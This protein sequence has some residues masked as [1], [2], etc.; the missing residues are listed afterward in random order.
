MA[1]LDRVPEFRKI[2]I[3]NAW[4]EY[5]RMR[6]LCSRN[7][8]SLEE[9]IKELTQ[10]AGRLAKAIAL[11]GNLESLVEELTRLN[12]EIAT[13]LLL[14]DVKDYLFRQG[15][16]VAPGTP[17]DFAKYIKSE[18]VKWEKVIKA[19]GLYKSN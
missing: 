12:K 4:S 1:Y 7:G 5:Q 16:D 17:E 10:Q 18:T 13:I 3:E 14:P 8:S 9:Q 6:G 19:A 15:M 11:G 2:V